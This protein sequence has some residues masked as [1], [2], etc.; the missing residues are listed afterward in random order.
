MSAVHPHLWPH[1]LRYC[2]GDTLGDWYFTDHEWSLSHL[3]PVVFWHVYPVFLSAGWWSRMTD[4]L[5]LPIMGPA[6][7]WMI[8]HVSPMQGLRD[9][10][11][12]AFRW[13][14]FYQHM[15]SHD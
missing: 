14:L 12:P 11:A 2:R 10:G 1:D 7:P 9:P 6:G 5:L 3:M 4:D 15:R 8:E 13:H